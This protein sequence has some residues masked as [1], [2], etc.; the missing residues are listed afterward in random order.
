VLLRVHNSKKNLVFLDPDAKV[1][2]YFNVEHIGFEDKDV[3]KATFRFAVKRK[4]LTKN[5]IP[6]DAVKVMRYNNGK[7]VNVQSTQLLQGDSKVVYYE[8]THTTLSLFAIVGESEDTAVTQPVKELP[9][10]QSK[11]ETKA[12]KV[13][14]PVVD[15]LVELEQP[16]SKKWT[17]LVYAGIALLAVL[18]LASPLYLDMPVNEDVTPTEDLNAIAEE[19]EAIADAVAEIDEQAGI[20]TQSWDANTD[21]TL[22][23]SEYFIDPDQESL[24]YTHTDLDH[25][26][27]AYEGNIAR[28]T[29]DLDWT[30]EEV[31]VFTATDADNATVDSNPVTLRVSEPEQT[32]EFVQDYGTYVLLALVFLVILLIASSLFKRGADLL[33]DKD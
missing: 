17:W 18:V 9:V 25:I 13:K 4:W 19:V 27:I 16:E 32:N 21:N 22:D 15:P 8:S 6:E 10:K 14:E 2:G 3:E 11:K 31:V 26:S 20:P 23:L 30:G 1:F 29:P 5:N 33:D 12:P 28:M 24:E 7:W